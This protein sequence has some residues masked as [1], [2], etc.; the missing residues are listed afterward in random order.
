VQHARADI[1]ADY[2]SLLATALL[3]TVFCAAAA[4]I[5]GSLGALLVAAAGALA[6]RAR[7]GRCRAPG[8]GGPVRRLPARSPPRNPSPRHRHGG[9]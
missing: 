6:P 9:S 8:G 1:L 3:L 5:G 7:L 4:R 2:V